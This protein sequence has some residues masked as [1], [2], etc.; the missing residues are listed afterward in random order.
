MSEVLDR[1]HYEY[2]QPAMGGHC[3]LLMR[4]GKLDAFLLL[5]KL[6]FGVLLC[7][8]LK[9][10]II[11]DLMLH[12]IGGTK[13]V[14]V[15]LDHSKGSRWILTGNQHLVLKFCVA[16]TRIMI[17]SG[18]LCCHDIYKFMTRLDYQN[19]HSKQKEISQDFNYELCFQNGSL[20]VSGLASFQK[21]A[22]S[23][24]T[25]PLRQTLFF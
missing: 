23:S 22:W 7:S 5:C 3:E 16:L 14:F 17:T 25:Y 20:L 11:H 24:T 15:S 18:H 9:V 12:Y 1:R 13:I 4:H 8:S 2:T 19:Y 21:P 10:F 6:H